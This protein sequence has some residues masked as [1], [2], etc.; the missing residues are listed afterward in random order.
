MY[1]SSHYHAFLSLLSSKT[2]P[3][4]LVGPIVHEGGHCTWAACALVAGG[5]SSCHQKVREASWRWS[6]LPLLPPLRWYLPRVLAPYREW[7]CTAGE[8]E[9]GG[10]AMTTVAV[11]KLLP[12]PPAHRDNNGPLWKISKVVHFA[13]LVPSSLKSKVVVRPPCPSDIEA[14]APLSAKRF[15]FQSLALWTALLPTAGLRVY[16]R[17]APNHY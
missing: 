13:C 16:A 1:G 9:G 14:A 3:R 15:C 5:V 4:L 2:P 10:V 12:Q 17:V 11:L 7:V 8:E 6:P